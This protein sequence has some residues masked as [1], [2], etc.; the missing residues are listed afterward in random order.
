MRSNPF[1]ITQQVALADILMRPGWQVRRGLS[2]GTVDRYAAIFKAG[3]DMDPV[4]LAQIGSVLVLIDGAHRMEAQRLLGKGT[5]EASVE[6]MT[7]A[8]AEWAAASANLEHGLPLK[9]SELREVFRHYIATSQHRTGRG[10][11]K[12]L[13]DIARDL[14][15]VTY[16]T[17]RNWLQADHPDLYRKSYAGSGAEGHSHGGLMDVQ[18]PTQ[19]ELDLQATEEHIRQAAALA[20]LMPSP[21]DRARVATLWAQHFGPLVAQPS[22]TQ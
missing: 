4:R 13:R 5:I 3:G 8:R 11:V 21:A 10:R 15:G 16:G 22:Q 1:D 18:R 12:S 6:K 19:R 9:K 14:P 7:E 2:A 20:T 17:V